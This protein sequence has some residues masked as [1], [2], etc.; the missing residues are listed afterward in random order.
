MRRAE[1][2]NGLIGGVG[3]EIRHGEARGEDPN[4]RSSRASGR[5]PCLSLPI[6]S[7]SQSS[8][9]EGVNDL[10]GGIGEDTRHLEGRGEDPSVRSP[11]I[12][13][14]GSTPN[15]LYNPSHGE[16]AVGDGVCGGLGLVGEDI[17]HFEGRGEDPNVRSPSIPSLDPPPMS[18]PIPSHGESM[19][20]DDACDGEGR[21]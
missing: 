2:V 15:P 1:G 10:V 13:P 3:E 9:L 4:V 6:P 5:V 8:S 16:I 17:H 20:P 11:P 19:V 14:I 12:G 18:L 21:L 7:H